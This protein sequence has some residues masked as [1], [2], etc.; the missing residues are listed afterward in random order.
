MKIKPRDIHIFG[1]FRH[2]GANDH[3]HLQPLAIEA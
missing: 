1:R 2:A 3:T